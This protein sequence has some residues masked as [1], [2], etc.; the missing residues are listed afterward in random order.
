M[1]GSVEEF[2]ISR[3]RGGVGVE[4]GNTLHYFEELK[5]VIGVDDGK[6]KDGDKLV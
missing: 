4:R 6:R 2:T 3:Q 5:K 1:A